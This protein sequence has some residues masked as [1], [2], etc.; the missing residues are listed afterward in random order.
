[1]SLFKG[2]KIWDTVTSTYKGLIFNAGS[3]QIC[4]QDYLQALAEGDI[5]GHTPW[6]K[7]GYNDTIGTSQETMWVNSTEYVFPT[8]A[9]QYEVISSS[10]DDD[11][12]PAGTGARTVMIDYLKSDYS[13]GTVTLTLNGNTA[14]PTGASHGDIWRIQSFR[15]LTAGGTGPLGT[16]TLRVV[17]AGA[18]HGLIRPGRTR[19]RSCFF[20]VPLGKTLYVTSIAFSA[21]GT[22]YLTFT[23]HANYNNSTGTIP[24]RT[25]FYPYSEVALLNSSYSKS[26]LVPTKLIATTDLKV[27]VIAE[28]AGSLATCHLRGWLE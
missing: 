28:A 6:S 15:V 4:A 16:L 17:S 1:M 25:L 24:Q 19:A 8:V 9:S 10:S 18:T 11:G 14:V 27:S 21:V 22:K 26:L 3:P 13:E 7:L 12:D 2:I 5:T 23:T 20:T